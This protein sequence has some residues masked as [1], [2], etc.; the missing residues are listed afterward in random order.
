[1]RHCFFH[2]VDI[3]VAFILKISCFL[4]ARSSQ[5]TLNGFHCLRTGAAHKSTN[6]CFH[7]VTEFTFSYAIEE[8]GVWVFRMKILTWN[9][10][11]RQ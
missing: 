10:L 5:L 7:Q 8:I 11:V 9:S 6:V 2:E 4:F 3:K 1:M